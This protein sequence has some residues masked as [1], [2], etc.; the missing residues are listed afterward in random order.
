M[1]SINN[2]G[3]TVDPMYWVNT[4]ERG[5]GLRKQVSRSTHA[6]WSPAAN[7]LP[8]VDQLNA[9][10]EGRVADLIPLRHSKMAE[11]SFAFLR[12]MPPTMANDL[13]NTPNTGIMVQACGDAHVMNF[14]LF[15]SPE[16]V[17]MFDITDFDE[18]HL[19]PWEWDVKRLAVS[20]A[21][22]ARQAPLELDDKVQTSLVKDTVLSY[23]EHIRMYS[24]MTHREIW[25]ARQTSEDFLNNMPSDKSRERLSASL[26]HA[27]QRTGSHL[28]AKLTIHDAEGHIR[29]RDE[30]PS[31]VHEAEGHFSSEKAIQTFREYRDKLQDDRKYLL[32]RYE[33]LDIARKVV[34]VGSVGTRCAVVLLRADDGDLLVLQIK[35]ARVSVL[36]AYTQACPYTHQGQRVVSGQRLMQSASDPFLGWTQS[37]SGVPFYVRQLRDMKASV[38]LVEMTAGELRE[39]AKLCGCCLA[40]A[41][42]K[43]GSSALIAGYLGKTDLFD[44]AISQFALSYADQNEKDYETFLAAKN[45]GKLV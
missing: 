9:S 6:E 5:K 19:A 13:S 41:H 12:G 16:R 28:L 27:V 42:A 25:Y 17:L 11:S 1:E 39:F 21:V 36:E 20:V 32:D 15:A 43:S 4:I 22:A 37:P 31:I 24:R 29:I 45:A 3:M 33:F 35:E 14:G 30:V 2:C 40:R 34:G 38:P 7:R 23:R 26:Q 8:I 18:T 44:R 10:N